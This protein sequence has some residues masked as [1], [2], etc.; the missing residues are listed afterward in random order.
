MVLP[1]FASI[2]KRGAGLGPATAFLYAGPAI[3]I[4]AII[5]TARVLGPRLGTARAVG[6]VLFSVVLGL[7]MHFL[8]RRAEALR[9]GGPV[10]LPDDPASR[11]LWKEGLYFGAMVGILAFAN[12]GAPA[13]GETVLW[14]DIYAGKWLLTGLLGLML[15][16]SLY[17][18]FQREELSN[19]VDAS[20][21]SGPRTR[22]CPRD[23]RR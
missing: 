2:H 22:S 16:G 21:G 4:L 9:T 13:E 20:W 3:N 7:A 18:W 8:F 14:A 1:L 5:L 19:W 11:P 12:W 10:V 15:G 17:G 23:R 6:A